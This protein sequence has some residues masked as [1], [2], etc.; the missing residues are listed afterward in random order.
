MGTTA[1]IFLSGEHPGAKTLA[2]LLPA[3]QRTIAADGGWDVACSLGVFPDTLIGDMDSIVR[4]PEAAAAPRVI[5]HPVHK[6]F[7]DTELAL[8]LAWQ[9]GCD[10]T[11]LFGGGG[12]RLDHLLAIRHLFQRPRSPDRWYTGSDEVILI[13]RPFRAVLPLNSVLSLFPL[14]PHECRAHSTGLTWPLDGLVWNDGDFGLGNLSN[15][16]EIRIEPLAGRLLLV[17]QLTEGEVIFP[18][19]GLFG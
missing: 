19:G 13:D 10:Q 8:E 11:I 15:Q 18:M 9:E 14:G 2:G 16:A 6:D 12:G 4:P 5:R 1:L 3:C 7:T 17:R